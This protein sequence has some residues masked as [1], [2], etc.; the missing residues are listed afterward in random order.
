MTPTTRR[1]VQTGLWGRAETLPAATAARSQTNDLD[2]IHSVIRTATEPGYVVIGPSERVHLREPGNTSEVQRVPTYEADAVAQLL[3]SGHFKIGGTHTVC[4]G[5][6]EGPA[7][8]VLVTAAARSMI[9]RWD[10]LH[11]LR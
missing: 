6:R 11:P 5:R 9:R 4:V 2:L 7:R 10:A 1:P 8:S 3:A